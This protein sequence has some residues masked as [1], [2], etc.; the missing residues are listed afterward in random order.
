MNREDVRLIIH[1]SI[2]LGSWNA[3]ERAE[4]TPEKASLVTATATAAT[5][6]RI[7]YRRLL[8]KSLP[9]PLFFKPMKYRQQ[10]R[11]FPRVNTF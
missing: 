5:I 2:T 1:K 7:S 6:H 9:V 4:E 11:S 10:L 3:V 8:Y